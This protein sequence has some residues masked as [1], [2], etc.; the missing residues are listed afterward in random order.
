MERFTIDTLLQWVGGW[1]PPVLLAVVGG[2]VR[3]LR[4]RNCTVRQWIASLAGAA[5]AGWITS[6]V[7]IAMGAPES[8][9]GPCSALAGYSGGTLLDVCADRLCSLARNAKP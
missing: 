9:I 8:F 3:Q 7:M 2:V 4:A 6:S 1:L 5:L